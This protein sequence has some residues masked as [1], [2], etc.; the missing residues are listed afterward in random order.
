MHVLHA[1]LP[2]CPDSVC[3]LGGSH[4]MACIV[5]RNP[6]GFG[7]M[8]VGFHRLR[9]IWCV[10][11]T[12]DLLG[13]VAL[14]FTL[15]LVPLLQVLLVILNGG[16][17]VGKLLAALRCLIMFFAQVLYLRFRL[18]RPLLHALPV[19]AHKLLVLHCLLV[20]EELPRMEDSLQHS[21]LGVAGEQ[22]SHCFGVGR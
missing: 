11:A 15:F 22:L 21:L 9:C 17:A 3:L 4:C 14:L 2:R 12:I 5:G 16:E 10:F 13:E 20:V 1:V 8:L 7:R 19:A 18:R 6:L